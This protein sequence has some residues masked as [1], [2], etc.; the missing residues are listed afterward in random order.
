MIF[1]S[2]WWFKFHRLERSKFE[3]IH[4][5]IKSLHFYKFYYAPTKIT[6]ISIDIC[7]MTSAYDIIIYIKQ[8]YLFCGYICIIFTYFMISKMLEILLVYFQVLIYDW[9]EWY[10]LKKDNNFYKHNTKKN[11]WK[12]STFVNATTIKAL[13]NSR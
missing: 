11:Q 8:I 12:S 6:G 13:K 5:F 2:E 7:E 10:G 1:F 9:W 4:L 3:T